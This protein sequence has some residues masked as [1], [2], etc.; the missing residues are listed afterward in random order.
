[1]TNYVV[2]KQAKVAYEH[3]MTPSKPKNGEKTRFS[4][5]LLLDDTPENMAMLKEQVNKAFEIGISRA[6]VT[7]A[8][9]PFLSVP[10]DRCDDP[11]PR[12]RRSKPYPQDF[13]GKIIVS[14]SSDEKFPPDMRNEDGSVM[15]AEECHSGMIGDAVVR[16]YCY[17][18]G[19][20]IGIG[21]AIDVFRKTDDGDRIG[22]ERATFD[23]VF[24]SGK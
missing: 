4:A 3:L 21:C 22:F 1:M 6:I 18:V 24:G 20:N 14:V 7:E 2:L 12:K 23:E 15:T 19:P 9:A 5:A 10:Y 11:N 13:A 16:F 17:A 8:D